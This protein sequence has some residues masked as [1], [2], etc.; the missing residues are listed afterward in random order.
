MA[1]MA[2]PVVGLFT[3]HSARCWLAS[4]AALLEV[5]EAD[6]ANL[7]RWSP[8]TSKGYVRTATE[9]VMRVQVTVAQRL[10]R[11]FGGP[12]EAIAGEQAAYLDL[13][14][15][16]IRRCHPEDVI[17]THLDEMQAWTAQLVCAVPPEPACV[18]AQVP[19]LTD[20]GERA[21]DAAEEPSEADEEADVVA[22]APPTPPCVP[23]AEAEERPQLP[24]ADEVSG[25]RSPATWCLCRSPTG[26]ACTALAG[27]P[28]TRGCIICALSSSG[29]P[30]RG[31]SRT[32]TFAGSAGGPGGR[33]RTRT[34]PSPR[35][36]PRKTRCRCSWTTRWSCSRRRCSGSSELYVFM[37]QV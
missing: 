24:V 21:V 37:V 14:R 9:V 4:M 3:Q 36:S 6:L 30:S 26:G 2:E 12:V 20:A 8:T 5:G 27:A 25:P 17:T 32:T 23:P 19:V 15:E 16:L 7:G 29:T 31:R 18:A 13:R 1:S 22:A 34:R 28:G 11:D 10:R 35:R 33:R